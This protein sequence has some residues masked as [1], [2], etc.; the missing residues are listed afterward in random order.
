ME[1]CP[2]SNPE[3]VSSA[4]GGR[5]P[6]R[7]SSQRTAT[8]HQT[9]TRKEKCPSLHVTRFSD[10]PPVKKSSNYRNP[11]ATGFRASTIPVALPHL[12]HLLPQRADQSVGALWP[13]DLPSL[14]SLTAW[15]LVGF[16]RANVWLWGGGGLLVKLTTCPQDP[17]SVYDFWGV[18]ANML[19]K[20]FH[21]L[22][23][24]FLFCLSG[25]SAW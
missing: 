15:H 4:E 14:G 25:F 24:R 20:A 3:L 11:P 16:W 1:Q 8:L 17:I 10:P 23:L 12:H 7:W 9:T 18:G 2:C 5:W 13:W 19:F 21:I 6:A 22:S